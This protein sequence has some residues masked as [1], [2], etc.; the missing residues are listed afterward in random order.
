MSTRAPSCVLITDNRLA[1][2]LVAAMLNNNGIMA[3]IKT[4]MKESDGLVLTPFANSNM[5]DHLEIHVADLEQ[6]QEA[7]E[8]IAA[9]EELVAQTAEK[10]SAP[11]PEDVIVACEACGKSTLFAGALQGSVQDCPECGAYMDI[12]GG[13]EEFDWS[14]VDETIAEDDE[15]YGSAD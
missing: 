11:P 2:D 5:S 12:P 4:H 3:E 6:V 10:L 13:E 9:N 7:E 15:E 8:L 14:V 1:A